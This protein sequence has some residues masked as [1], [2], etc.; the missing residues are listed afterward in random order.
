[1]ICLRGLGQMAF[2]ENRMLRAAVRAAE[3]AVV[4]HKTEHRHLHHVGHAYRFP[5]NHGHQLL[6][7]GDDNHA[8]YRQGLEYRQRNVPRSGRHIDKHIIDVLPDHIRPELLH[9]ARDDRA[10]PEHRVAG[11]VQQEVNGHNLNT[12]SAHGRMQAR[13]LRPGTFLHTEGFGDGGPSDIRVQNCRAHSA[14]LH[15]GGQHG[16]DGTLADAALSGHNGNDLLYLGLFIQ[17]GEK[18]LFCP[19]AAVFA[20]GSA[21]AAAI[22]THNRF[23]SR[24]LFDL[25]RSVFPLR[26]QLFQ[27]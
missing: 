16:R 23:S 7:R 13:L 2:A 26:H 8:V 15:R 21:I 4:F 6:R 19:F 24:K 18:A 9:R 17:S 1:M 3:I 5:H 27:F 10:A 12:R 20:A 22:F 14:A 11:I 25:C